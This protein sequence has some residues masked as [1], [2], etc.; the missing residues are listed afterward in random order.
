MLP[1]VAYRAATIAK[2]E[3]PVNARVAVLS[4]ACCCDAKDITYIGDSNDVL[5]ASEEPASA[6]V[7]STSPVLRSTR[8][9][10]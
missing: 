2:S 4:F 9:W 6:S 1:A 5:Y 7:S 10:T 3:M 8:P